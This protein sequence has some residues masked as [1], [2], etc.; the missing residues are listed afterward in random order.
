MVALFIMSIVE[1]LISVLRIH[2]QHQQPSTS[3]DEPVNRLVEAVHRALLWSYV[4][5][6]VSAVII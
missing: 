4:I 6:V 1:G 3:A 5:V 2:R